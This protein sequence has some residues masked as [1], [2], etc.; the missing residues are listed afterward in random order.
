MLCFSDG[1]FLHW[2]RQ[3]ETHGKIH[4]HT[5]TYIH[6]QCRSANG[7][8]G[9]NPKLLKQA[10]GALCLSVRL[11]ALLM[12]GRK[13]SESDGQREKKGRAVEREEEGDRETA[14]QTGHEEGGVR[15]EQSVKERERE[16]ERERKGKAVRWYQQ[17]KDTIMSH[18]TET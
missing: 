10:I 17:R 15:E 2:H 9:Q 6:M 18:C 12:E 1:F 8:L 3:N 13:E 16:R 5:H 7:Q 11:P 14:T 4:T